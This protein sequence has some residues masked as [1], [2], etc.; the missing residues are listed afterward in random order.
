M[1]MK[2]KVVVQGEPK[3]GTTEP[4]ELA[5]FQTGWEELDIDAAEMGKLVDDICDDYRTEPAT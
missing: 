3:A 1:R 5:A 4:T 2:V